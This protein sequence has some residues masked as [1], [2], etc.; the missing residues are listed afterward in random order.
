MNRDLRGAEEETEATA[1]AILMKGM[2][3]RAVNIRE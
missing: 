2:L 1:E 3:S